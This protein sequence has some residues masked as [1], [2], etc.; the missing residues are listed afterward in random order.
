MDG[1]VSRRWDSKTPPQSIHNGNESCLDSSLS[2]RNIKY[3]DTWL[4]LFQWFSTLA[5]K[6]GTRCGDSSVQQWRTYPNH[7]TNERHNHTNYLL[8]THMIALRSS[9]S[10]QFKPSESD[11][12]TYVVKTWWADVGWPI[13]HTHSI[14]LISVWVSCI[15]SILIYIYSPHVST[16]CHDSFVWQIPLGMSPILTTKRKGST[17]LFTTINCSLANLSRGLAGEHIDRHLFDASQRHHWILHD[18]L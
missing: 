7:S 2:N 17:I 4:R 13:K 12:T 1:R 14:V 8:F 3:I 11:F 9:K 15:S 10:P 6:M 16:W 18:C 5:C